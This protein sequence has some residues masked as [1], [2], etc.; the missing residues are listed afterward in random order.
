MMLLVAVLLLAAAGIGDEAMESLLREL[1]SDDPVVRSKAT[2][3]ILAAWPRW[4]EADLLELEKAAL[5][6]DPEVQGRAAEMHSRI[7]I[8]RTLGE[9]VFNRIAKVDD[10]FLRGDDAAKLAALEAAKALWK[11][12]TLRTEDLAGLERLAS[13]AP[14]TDSGA[15]DLLL[16]EPDA[17]QTFSLKEDAA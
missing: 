3:D 4:K 7:R 12:G 13:R 16:S 6:P 9:N 17:E 1:R 2:A 10:A 14:W 11:V 15:P 5:D 8:R